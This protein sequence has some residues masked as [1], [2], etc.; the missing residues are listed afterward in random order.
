MNFIKDSECTPDTPVILGKQEK[1]IYGNGVRLKPRVK[2]RCDSEHFKKI[3]LPRLL[4]LEEYDLIVVLISGGKDVVRYTMF[5]QHINEEI[6]QF[7]DAKKQ[8][9]KEIRG[10]RDKNMIQILTKVYVQFKTVKVASQEMKKSY[11]YTVELHNK[12]L[13]AF[14][15]T[16]KNLTYL[17]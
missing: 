6:D 3:Y 15:D 5:D 17:T 2:G 1:P 13:S 12:A 16:Y 4:P 14:E 9:I 10:L 11:S 7:V 8:I